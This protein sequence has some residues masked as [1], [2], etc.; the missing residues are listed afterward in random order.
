M[1]WFLSGHRA[2]EF[3]HLQHGHINYKEVKVLIFFSFIPWALTFSY[4]DKGPNRYW[5]SNFESFLCL[6]KALIF[7]VKSLMSL[8][9]LLNIYIIK[10]HWNILIMWIIVWKIWEF[11]ERELFETLKIV[12]L[13]CFYKERS[14]L[15]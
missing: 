14:Y 1:Y 11:F 4:R 5:N 12:H 10:C 2:L 15:R 3:L 7:W 6:Y 13:I 9:A 8:L